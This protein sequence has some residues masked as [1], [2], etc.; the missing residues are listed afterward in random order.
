M[1]VDG[2]EGRAVLVGGPG[3]DLDE[4]E[5]LAVQGD[6]VDLAGRGLVVAGDDAVAVALEPG[7][8]GGLGAA[9]PGVGVGL[10]GEAL[11]AQA[12]TDAGGGVEDLLLQ[13]ELLEVSSGEL[14]KAMEIYRRIA[15]DERDRII[16]RS[17]EQVEVPAVQLTIAP[18]LQQNA[19]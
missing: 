4:A 17:V 11:P 12:G 9:P 18:A 1:A 13:A 6:G 15:D 7:D 5:G 16:I 8:G 19:L 14:G 10:V 3:L 2:L